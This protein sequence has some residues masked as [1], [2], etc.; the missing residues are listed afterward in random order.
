M[1]TWQKLSP[2]SL[3]ILFCALFS[4]ACTQQ[5]AKS[6]VNLHDSASLTKLQIKVFKPGSVAPSTLYVIGQ[7]Q[8]QQ[9]Y[10]AA[11]ASPQPRKSS[12]C[13]QVLGADYQL[14]FWAGGQTAEIIAADRGGCGDLF[15]RG[16]DLRDASKDFWSL[17]DQAIASAPQVKQPDRLTIVRYWGDR[18]APLTASVTS[19]EQAQTLFLALSSLPPSEERCGGEIVTYDDLF[20]FEGETLLR[21][22]VPRGA[23]SQ[24]SIAGDPSTSSWQFTEHF[25]Q[26]MDQL[27]AGITL[28]PAQPDQLEIRHNLEHTV[29]GP[30]TIFY[31]SI[32]QS[33][34]QKL[35]QTVY[36]LPV[37]PANKDVSCNSQGTADSYDVLTFSQAGAWL[38]SVNAFSDCASLGLVRADMMGGSS[39]QV[40]PE[41]WD[42]VHRFEKG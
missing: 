5:P 34:V 10:K 40:T 6:L 30:Q 26:V 28:V 38:T 1:R 2:F 3:I 35:F 25:R 13:S 16:G 36:D 11:L 12:G 29:P 20:F 17:L 14:I 23:C 24:I 19:A 7:K 39:R 42:Q 33:A 18:Q 4:A 15:L 31:A 21:A 8:A 32:E 22:Y 41:F 37:W 9:I 27:L